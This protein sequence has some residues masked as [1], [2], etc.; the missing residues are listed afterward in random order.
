MDEVDCWITSL[1]TC[2]LLPESEIKKLCEK[3]LS[4]YV[5]LTRQAREILVTES[6]VQ[7]VHTPVTVCGDIHGNFICAFC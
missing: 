2:K 5:S 6:N 1:M 7:A 4:Q 3:V